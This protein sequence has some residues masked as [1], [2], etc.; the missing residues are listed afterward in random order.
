M[1]PQQDAPNT[2]IQDDGL[3]YKR[4]AAGSPFSTGGSGMH[5]A[6][7]S[8]FKCG[9]HRPRAELQ[10]KRLLGKNQLV[11]AAGCKSR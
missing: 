6:T 4:K 1:K 3:R 7:M 10:T 5:M 8:C 2:V 11:C 9:T